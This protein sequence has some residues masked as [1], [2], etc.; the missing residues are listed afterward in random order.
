MRLGLRAKSALALLGSILLVLALATAAGWRVVRYIEVNLGS[1]FAR[2]V[3][4]LNKQRILTPVLRE[5]ALAR[6]MADSQ[7]TLR[8]LKDENDPAK[9]AFFFAE[10]R[11]YQKSFADH[12]YFLITRDSR[13]YYFNDSRDAF[14]DKFRYALSKTDPNDA[15]FFSTM[16]SN[17]PFNINVNPDTKLKVTKVWFNVLVKDNGRN[18]GL[19]GTGLALNSFL[20]RFINN[21]EKGVTP[22]I[23]NDSGD[24]QAYPDP[25]RIDYA[26]VAKGA[27]HSTVFQLIKGKQ[28]IDAMHQAMALTKKHEDQIPVFWANINGSRKLLAVASLPELHWFVVTAVDLKEARVLSAEIWLPLFATGGVLL[29]IL[30]I[31]LMAAVNRVLL[32]PLLRLT[33]SAQTVAA[34][35]YDV[36]LPPAGGDELGQLTR[37]FA[38]MTQRV[39]SHTA[40]LE[41]KV[42]ERTSELV[43]V[44][45][46]IDDSIRY[47]RLIQDAILPGQEMDEVLREKYFVLWQPRDIVGGDFYLFR[48][49]PQGCLLGVVDC[50]GHGVPG[51]FM[52]MIAHSAL[53]VTVETRGIT[54]PAALLAGVDERIRAILQEKNHEI[55][56]ATHLDMG[57]VYLDYRQQTATYSGAKISLYCCHDNDVEELKGSRY[58]IGG[59]RQTAFVNHRR[60]AEPG[61]T[62]YFSTDGLLDQAGGD[63]GYG[64]GNSRFIQFLREYSHLPFP[65]Q[66]QALLEELS[67]YQGALPRRDDIT[68][69]GFSIIDPG[70]IA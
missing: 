3:T 51:A 64:F 39:R 45:R 47:A 9:K 28:D 58:A 14:S 60:K 54:D 56:V 27:H 15:W 10:A 19:A 41:D 52:T 2:N 4:R 49:S 31:I 16:K 20:N 69:M 6:Q 67:R 8:W 46:K 36:Q 38:T 57:L 65:R 62:F 24:I 5:L 23:I 61:D 66:K 21:S 11:Q 44:N 13:H 37:A 42:A 53:D 55:P 7:V 25:K 40:E 70:E 32:K 17:A 22:I 34:G 26:S 30:I 18:I 12:S 35:N 33:D 1:A 68:V 63:H 48:S 59:R 50:A 29:L 43:E